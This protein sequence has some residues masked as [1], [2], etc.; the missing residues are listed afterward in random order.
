MIRIFTSINILYKI[1]IIQISTSFLISQTSSIIFQDLIKNEE[2]ENLHNSFNIIFSQS[3]YFN[4]NLPNLENQN[5]LYFP[6]GYGVYTS[7]FYKYN[8]K[9]F[10]I[11]AEP[12]VWH[13]KLYS[14]SPPIKEKAF[15]VLNDVPLLS[16]NE[17]ENIRNIGMKIHLNKFSIGYGNWNQWWG[18]G[19]HN[20]LSLTNN[21][22]GFYHYFIEQQ[23][24]L[25][26]NKKIEYKMK[27]MV[28]NN[29]INT[30]Q[31]NFYLSLSTIYCA[32]Y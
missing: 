11:S 19:I 29:F 10:T 9:Y 17:P 1:V 4:S 3:Y 5:G 2:K 13:K 23:P 20:S 15:S 18:P 27:Y 8:N 16:Y 31:D 6:K 32:K 22:E 12:T 24:I 14:I 25:F 30:N 7:T 28:S 26:L 21:S